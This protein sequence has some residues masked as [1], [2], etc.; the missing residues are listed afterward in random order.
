MLVL[1]RHLVLVLLLLSHAC[2]GA[3]H[4]YRMLLWQATTASTGTCFIKRKT[5]SALI[6]T[7]T[8]T[9]LDEQTAG[10]FLLQ[11]Y[12]VVFNPFCLDKDEDNSD[13]PGPGMFVTYGVKHIK[14]WVRAF[15]EVSCLGSL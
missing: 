14:F 6:R 13:V 7:Y 11:V 3:N 4:Q 9:C 15:N 12:G 2:F 8:Q 1:S 10:L 5:E